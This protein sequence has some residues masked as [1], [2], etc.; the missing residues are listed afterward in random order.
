MKTIDERDMQKT[1][2]EKQTKA[3]KNRGD[4]SYTER[5]RVNDIVVH[6]S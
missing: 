6:L 2:K 1:K 4:R 3:E 5:V